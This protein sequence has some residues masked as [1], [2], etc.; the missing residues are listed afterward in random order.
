MS[1]GELLANVGFSH[2]L[3]LAVLAG[4]AVY[5]DV[6]ADALGVS[7]STQELLVGVGFGL[8]LAVANT[9][10]GAAANAL[11]HTPS[12][13]LRR[14]L[15]PDG[16][17]GWALLLA[18]VLPLVALFEEFLFRAALIGGLSAGFGLSPWLLAV[19]SSAAFAVGHGAQGRAGI[20]V[21]GLLGFVLAAGFVL[22]GSLLVVVVAH[23]LVN[24]AEFVIYE[25]LG[26]EL[27]WR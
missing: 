9:A 4:G 14:M 6:P 1:T 7:L 16:A 17:V 8:G 19:G 23:Y 26:V 2:G 24:A 3:F 21:T 13:D 5:A 15:A 25:G 18:V 11:G 27:A 20:A 22:T 12:E 10:A